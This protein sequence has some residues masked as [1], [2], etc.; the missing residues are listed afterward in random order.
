MNDL[1]R[2]YGIAWN[3]SAASQ[4]V[5]ARV[6]DNQIKQLLKTIG[7]KADRFDKNLDRAF[8]N[9]RTMPAAGKTRS[10]SPSK[11]S[12]RRPIDCAIASTAAR[13]TRST[14]RRCS[15]AA[16]ASTASCS[17]IS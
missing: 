12:S 7:Q 3:W 5:P 17:G 14:P 16:R 10:A 11:T 13:P 9:S 4:T 15:A 2:A 8:V 1:T 6:N